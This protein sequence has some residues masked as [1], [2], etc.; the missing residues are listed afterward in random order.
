MS[1]EIEKKEEIINDE[2][3]DVQDAKHKYS[4][5]HGEALTFF[6]SYKITADQRVNF[7]V[8]IGDS[9]SGKTTL[10]VTI[11]NL[12]QK[13]PFLNYYFAGSETLIGFEQ[14]C[15]LSRTT[16]FG[17]KPETAKTRRGVTDSL[18]HLELYNATDKT[19]K[20][21]LITDFSGED[22]TSLI[23][24]TD[25]AKNE[26]SFIK[27]A[28]C[29]ALLIDGDHLTDFNKRN[30]TEQQAYQMLNTLIDSNIINPNT[31]VDLAISKFDLVSERIKND[32]SLESFIYKL[33]A[34]F[35]NAFYNKLKN[36]NFINIA[37]RPLDGSELKMGYGLDELLPNWFEYHIMPK[38]D[39]NHKALTSYY[40]EFDLFAIRN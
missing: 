8:L 39:I 27:R 16:S 33:K 21:L 29:I 22:Y 15:H 9:G 3:L 31:R 28:D 34:K 17:I 32:P 37:M 12:L 18:L 36:Y 4:M 25:L 24:N 6:D 30:K 1:E 11:Y 19:K 14:R 20:N 40:S 10:I 23:G 35:K 2:S 13:G 7:I 5:H 26:Y 38:K